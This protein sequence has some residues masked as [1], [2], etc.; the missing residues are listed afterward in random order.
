MHGAWGGGQAGAVGSGGPQGRAYL[1]DHAVP[2]ASNPLAMLAVGHQVQVIG[3]LDHLGQLLEDVNAEALTAE[4]G[5]GGRVTAAA[6]KRPPAVRASSNS[7][8]GRWPPPPHPGIRHTRLP[9]HG[10]TQLTPG[11]PVP[12]HGPEGVVA[13]PAAGHS[14]GHT[15]A[16]AGVRALHNDKGPLFQRGHRQV[17]AVHYRLQGG[18][19]ARPHRV[20]HVEDTM[21]PATHLQKVTSFSLGPPARLPPPSRWGPLVGPAR[22]KSLP[23]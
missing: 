7:Q 9:S 2:H 13:L 16:R 3:E 8:Y 15:A 6:T 1:P 22:A 11:L 10:S 23:P 19:I 4:L 18:T 5:V 20:L 12:S 21:V 17:P 14:V